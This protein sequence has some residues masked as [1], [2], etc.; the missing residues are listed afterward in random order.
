MIFLDIR[1]VTVYFRNHMAKITAVTGD[2]QSSFAWKPI[3]WVVG[4]VAIL[5]LVLGGIGVYVNN[6]LD[7]NDDYEFN[8]VQDYNHTLGNQDAS[9]TVINFDDLQCPACRQNEA[10]LE[11][12]REEFAGDVRFVYKHN[13]L[14]DLHP[15]AKSAAYA[16]EAAGE[17]DKFFEYVYKLFENQEE[18]GN[19]LF[20]QIAEEEGLD[21]DKWDED[22]KDRVIKDRVDNDVRDLK[23]MVFPASSVNIDQSNGEGRTKNE[24]Q[25]TGTPTN[26]ILVDGEIVDWWTGSFNEAQWRA[27]I[28]EKLGRDANEP[29]DFTPGASSEDVEEENSDQ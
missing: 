6:F 21:L 11:P 12:I 16:A 17:Q 14:T 8:I 10:A 7:E 19:D 13:P 26:V 22:R 20:E 27:Y 29:V 23:N 5:A 9:L 18:I 24:G 4:I 15:L 25:Q 3:A 1:T 2:E 28:N